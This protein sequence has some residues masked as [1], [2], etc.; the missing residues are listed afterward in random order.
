[1]TAAPATAQCGPAAPLAPSP[2]RGRVRGRRHRARVDVPGVRGDERG[3]RP[4]GSSA[5]APASSRSTSPPA[6]RGPPG[7][8]RRRRPRSL[9]AVRPALMSRDPDRDLR[10][11]T[12]GVPSNTRGSPRHTRRTCRPGGAIRRGRSRRARSEVPH[13]G[14]RALPLDVGHVPRTRTGRSR[15]RYR[16]RERRGRRRWPVTHLQSGGTRWCIGT[17]G[18]GARP[19][20]ASSVIRPSRS[21]GSARRELTRPRSRAPHT[22]SS[23]APGR[24]QAHRRRSPL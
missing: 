5:R 24:R 8:T 4:P 23:R 2:A 12:P 20:S 1:V 3:G 6:R 9:M 14:Q 21:A 22:R 11:H 19:P 17:S 10:D 15:V 7:R 16:A 18:P 13:D